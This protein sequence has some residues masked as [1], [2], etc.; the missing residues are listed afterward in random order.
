MP[1][2]KVE[3]APPA[4]DNL[5]KDFAIIQGIWGLVY[6]S[7][8]ILVF[9]SVLFYS[10]KQLT[11]S[12]NVHLLGPYLGTSLAL[13]MFF[14]FGRIPSF[15]FA[16]AV[17]YIG[18]AKL[19]GN[20]LRSK[21]LLFL[22][23]L[24]IE[25]CLLLAIR[26]T[27]ELISGNIRAFIFD[28]N[29]IS[30]NHVGLL[31][32]HALAPLFGGRVFG[33]YFITSLLV[34]ITV[35]TGLRIR[36][37]TAAAFISKWAAAVWMW[38]IKAFTEVK[39]GIENS[40]DIREE[41]SDGD[42]LVNK[43]EI[44]KEKEIS[45][46]NPVKESKKKNNKAEAETVPEA[47][48]I[49]Q[50]AE[51]QPA[52]PEY[53]GE[54]SAA[55]AAAVAEQAA[56]ADTA[57]APA[58]WLEN[59]TADTSSPSTEDVKDSEIKNPVV[60]ELEEFRKKRETPI[61]ILT[62]E[63][64]DVEPQMDDSFLPIESGMN[65]D[66][67]PPLVVDDN[68]DGE[69]GELPDTDTRE[70]DPDS[71]DESEA[72]GGDENFIVNEEVQL[73]KPYVLPSPDI[74]EDP[75]PL[76]KMYNE[77]AINRNSMI[78]E[79]T[80]L[81]FKVEGKVISVSPGPV[82]TRYEI[83]LAP[84]IKVNKV[85]GLHDDI[86]MAVG[87]QKIRI[88]APIPGKSAVGIELPNAERQNVHFKHILISDTFKKGSFKLPVIIGSN[89]S[90]APYV[91]DITK[92]PHLLIAGQ[93]GAGKSVC[94]NSL[95]CT[96]LMTKT[97]DELRLIMVDPKQVEF[98]SYE[99]I[100]HLLS[101][102]VTESKEAVKALQWGVLEMERRYSL[103]AKA[104]V[105]KIDD[106]NAKFESGKLAGIISDEDNK[107]LPFIV[108]II[109]E[110]ADLMM[111]ASKDVEALIMRITQKA[112]AAGMHLIVATQRPSVNVITGPIKANLPS[113]IAFRTVQANDSRT[114][115]DQNGSE[116]LLGMGDMLFLRNGAPDIERF[117]GAFIPD[118]DVE[119]IVDAIRSQHVQIETISSFNDVIDDSEGGDSGGASAV[120]D[121]KR[122]PLFRDAAYLIASIGQGS[123]SLLQRKFEIGFAR[124]GRLMD[125]L[126]RFGVVGEAKGSK[127]REVL[128][129]SDDLDD[130]F[131][132]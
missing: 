22:S 70:I 76:S 45:E 5:K 116:E 79:K 20:P 40:P 103:L 33:P 21:L 130:L 62:I 60:D 132:Q 48:P 9:I 113:R 120:D 92:T 54:E 90:G 95:I 123:T 94:M 128:M 131:R 84:G 115:L 109:D 19:R 13:G 89:I 99:N 37:Q 15:L 96:L 4:A 72:G 127:A 46:E 57:F 6:L 59:L 66:V 29:N 102:V 126:E 73:T 51:Q 124:A 101:P 27:P 58:G 87:G 63:T 83:E 10:S 17:S 12:S 108:I 8:G 38:I 74:L 7:I 80:L 82:V 14:L 71:E 32:V 3:K 85:T 43:T 97:P 49:P 11:D 39:T 77:E 117:H 93:T 16:A 1:R 25:L 41:S 67:Y 53:T 34:I 114:I 35:M 64:P 36:P 88:Q 18:W 26:Y 31:M 91:T 129:R 105:R 52:I 107:Q 2:K 98:T 112:R 65:N 44:G 23:V 24:S 86:S 81:S 110:L 47:V 121:G 68:D 122:D 75:P 56:A 50:T 100:P 119:R 78:L 55:L 104:G 125:Q 61:K 106:F 118:A 111:T 28:P 42:A 69:Y 30:F